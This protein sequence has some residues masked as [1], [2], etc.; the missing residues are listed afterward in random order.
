M[1]YFFVGA[2]TGLIAGLLLAPKPGIENRGMVKERFSSL[3]DKMMRKGSADGG[4][5]EEGGLEST[6]RADYLH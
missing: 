3:R 5:L 1:N 2:V 4:G 6:V